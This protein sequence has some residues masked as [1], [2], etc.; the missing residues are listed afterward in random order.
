V[1]TRLEIT[2][3]KVLRKEK[4]NTTRL[5]LGYSTTAVAVVLLMEGQLMK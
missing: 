4:R 5:E 2:F 1:P 3:R